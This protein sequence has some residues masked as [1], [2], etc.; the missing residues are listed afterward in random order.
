[1]AFFDAR[2]HTKSARNRRLYAIYQL[3]YTA[4]DFSAAVLFLIGS[5][6]FFYDSLQNPAIWCFVVGS[7]LFAAKPTLRIAREIHYLMK[8]DF[9]DLAEQAEG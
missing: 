6:M 8:G 5:I 2:N 3:V 4:V 7:V 9:E 1:M